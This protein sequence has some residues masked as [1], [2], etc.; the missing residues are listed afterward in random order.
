MTETVTIRAAVPAD[1]RAIA[2]VHVETWRSAYAGMLPDAVVIGMSVDREAAAW[3]RNLGRLGGR[4]SV[5]VAAAEASHDAGSRGEVVGFATCGAAGWPSPAGEVQMLYVLPDWQDRGIGCALLRACFQKLTAC[6]FAQALVWV[7]A[8]NPSRF[9][10]EAQG[11]RQAGEREETLW[12][13]RLR[14]IAY[15]WPAIA[16]RPLARGG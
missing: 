1:A 6:G 5:L 13:V 9:F 7:L 8:D 3:R 4:D 11:G 15:L 14:E 10:Y 12:G 2:R 16:A